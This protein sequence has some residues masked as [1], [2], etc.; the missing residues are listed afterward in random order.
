MNALGKH[1]VL[2]LGFL[3]LIAG[4]A[5]AQTGTTEKTVCKDAKTQREINECLASAY[6]NADEELNTFYS[7]LRKKFDSGSEQR[8]RA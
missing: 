2:C 3:L 5:A 8:E 1:F 4:G 7:T 6:R